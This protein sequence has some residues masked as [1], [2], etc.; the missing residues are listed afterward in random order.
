MMTDNNDY[1][2]DVDVFLLVHEVTNQSAVS[3]HVYI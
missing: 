3:V 1:D 2:H